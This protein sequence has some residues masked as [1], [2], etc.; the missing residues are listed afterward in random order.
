MGVS[1][2]LCTYKVIDR[3]ERQPCLL[4]S[5]SAHTYIL[6]RNLKIG[7]SCYRQLI[8]STQQP[9]LFNPPFEC[10]NGTKWLLRH[11][12]SRKLI[13]DLSGKIQIPI[14]QKLSVWMTAH[15][16]IEGH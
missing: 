4:F 6:K 10:Q 16:L 2:K 8:S 14:P 7:K 13:C 3:R 11:V 9:V 1:V 15:I 12:G 5:I